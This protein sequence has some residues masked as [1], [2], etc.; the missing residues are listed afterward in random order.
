MPLKQTL[1][2]RTNIG[3]LLVPSWGIFGTKMTP[4]DTPKL[5]T[6]AGPQTVHKFRPKM[7]P[8]IGPAKATDVIGRE[9][10]VKVQASCC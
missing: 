4:K 8:N 3:V 10:D 7:T 9:V 1:S 6:V 5:C 2:H